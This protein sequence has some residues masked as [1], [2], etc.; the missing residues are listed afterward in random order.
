MQGPTKRPANPL[1]IPP[2]PYLF[3]GCAYR[4]SE[5]VIYV[6]TRT[7]NPPSVHR[8]AY[9]KTPAVGTADGLFIT[10]ECIEH[11]TAAR[12]RG[13]SGILI[14]IWSE[15]KTHRVWV[16]CA[17]WTDWRI[18]V[19]FSCRIRNLNKNLPDLQRVLR[20]SLLLTH[21]NK[22]CRGSSRGS[23]VSIY[24]WWWELKGK[25]PLNRKAYIPDLKFVISA[26]SPETRGKILMLLRLVCDSSLLIIYER[27][28]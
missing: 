27:L 21:R 23:V 10:L 5:K 28:S 13:G 17:G 12:C 3:S 20:P 16:I 22:L 6:Q 24:K 2:P 8:P 26:F 25:Y 7:A 15:R 9:L 1:Q 19:V 18:N 11:Y 4:V 14:S